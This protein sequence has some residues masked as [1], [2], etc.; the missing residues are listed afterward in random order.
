MR[1]CAVLCAVLALVGARPALAE[2][3]VGIESR[4]QSAELELD[5]VTQN[6]VD[7]TAA[8]D[9]GTDEI[10][11]TNS[12]NAIR[13]GYIQEIG[14][15]LFLD[16]SIAFGSVRMSN[17]RQ[18]FDPAAPADTRIEASA[19]LDSSFYIDFGAGVRG[20]AGSISYTGDFRLEMS[21]AEQDVQTGAGG[22]N[23]LEL[24]QRNIVF[25]G[26][27]GVG[28]EVRGFVGLGLNFYEM[29]STYIELPDTYVVV[30]KYKLPLVIFAG[31]ESRGEQVNA[32]ARVSLIGE[33][34]L[35]MWAGVA[36]KF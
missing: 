4:V 32:F 27:I 13:V 24:D 9:A 16:A 10:V 29:E 3:Y 21:S 23:T 5:E 6:G 15:D 26:T 20:Q 8:F 14:S 17:V 12:I 19:T 35:S 36:M 1:K 22:T 25:E 18:E 30:T 31:L 33:K 34:F 2:F 11:G 28:E 7:V